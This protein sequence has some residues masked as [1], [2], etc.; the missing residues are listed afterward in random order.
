MNRRKFLAGSVGGVVTTAQ[1]ARG[2]SYPK[3]STASNN[4]S[5]RPIVIDAHAH[6]GYM[7]MW[8]QRDISF[9]DILSAAD[10]AGIDK[11]CVSSLEAIELEVEEGNKAIH[12][13]MKWVGAGAI[14]AGMTMKASTPNPIAEEAEP[15]NE[16]QVDV[17]KDRN[18]GG[19]WAG[20]PTMYNA[21]WSLDMGAMETNIKRMIKI[22]VHGIYLLGSTGEFY[23][24][25]FDE[26]KLLADLLVRTTAGTGIPTCVVC[27]SPNT[28]T[29]L[30]Q[31]LYL[32]K[33]GVTAA[34]L[35]IPFWMEMTEREFMQFF[36][37]VHE[38]VPDLPIIHYNIPRTKR[39]LLG[40]DYVKVREVLPNLAA[41][42]FTFAGS[43]FGD[44]REAVR[45]NPSL[46][47]LVGENLLVSG[48]QIGADGS[49]S[50]IVYTNPDTVLKMYRLAKQ[51]KWDEAQAMQNR[52]IAF[53]AGVFPTIE[54]LGEGYIDPVADKGL[55]LAA[56]G[57]VG[58]P[59][60][61][62]PY[63]GWSEESVRAVRA[64]M[65]ENFPD[66]LAKE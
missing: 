57:I 32:R 56:G 47:F 8:G 40:P 44:L 43:H 49:C 25:D 17:S 18:L 42:K 11:L 21:D 35:V 36:K 55:G 45:L 23:A 14:A 41:V 27:G 26:F 61:R 10:E 58:H 12:Q 37:D 15:M 22:E 52:I 30:R 46:K 39:F 24:M 65:K 62:A 2:S 51:R 53:F 63:I 50:S 28:R 60:T 4:Q 16:P 54:K 64:W 31:L 66:F 13:F 1:M 5:A 6:F 29:T 59:R 48:M 38:A 7:G 9:E 33:S 19:I 3:G 34:Q 20:L